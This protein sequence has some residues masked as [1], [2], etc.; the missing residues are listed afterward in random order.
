MNNF[1]LPSDQDVTSIPSVAQRR[2]IFAGNDVSRNDVTMPPR[3]VENDVKQEIA[4]IETSSKTIRDNES[5]VSSATYEKS[6]YDA[7]NSV[8]TSGN[9]N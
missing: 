5:D 3:F 1:F 8:M 6:G 7:D 9:L 2:S 4:S